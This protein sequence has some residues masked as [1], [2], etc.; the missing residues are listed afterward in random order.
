MM[1]NQ[2]NNGSS[3]LV[4]LQNYYSISEAERLSNSLKACGVCCRESCGD[5]AQA[6]LVL[7]GDSSPWQETLD[8]VH[9]CAHKGL[10]TLCLGLFHRPVEHHK[11]WELLAAGADEFL[12]WNQRER[13]EQAVLAKLER[14]TTVSNLLRS[15]RVRE[16]LV[17]E[18]PA[19]Q[20]LLGQVVEAAYFSAAPVLILGESGTGKE[21][22]AKLIHDLDRRP[23]KRDWVITDCATIVPELSGSEFFGHEKGAFTNAV[24][25]RDGAFALADGGTLF[26]DEI[27]ELPLTLQAE[28]LRAIQEGTYKRVGSNYWRQSKFRLVSATNRNLQ[29]ET[30][31]GRFREDL[32]FRISTCICHMPPLRDRREDIPALARFFLKKYLPTDTSPDFDEVVRHYLMT[33]DYRGNVRELQQLVARI[34]Y[35][36][37]GKGPISAGDLPETDRPWLPKL[38]NPLD[39]T[40]LE[41]ALRLA[42]ANGTGLKEIKRLIGNKLMDLV[43]ADANG[44]LQAAAQRLQ[45][46]DRTLQLH[47]AG[48]G[49]LSEE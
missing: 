37:T 42:V 23:D 44:D 43:I 40:S 4:W 9:D 39:D 19:W 45:V 14:W 46:S 5:D 11:I 33:R 35:R 21:L 15:A 29:Q 18:S 25:N 28:L 1:T 20:R 12:D 49:A 32:F 10:R 38:L 34:A 6:A 47:A 41:N 48:K 3:R 17:G 16:Q 22:V 26:L 24:S 13:P 8:F 30:M 31:E 2:T 36:H 7:L 27:G